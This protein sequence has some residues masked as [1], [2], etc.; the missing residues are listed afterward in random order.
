MVQRTKR[1]WEAG[2]LEGGEAGKLR[3]LRL[4]ATTIET[5]KLR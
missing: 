4:K 3:S 5:E 1:G 2:K